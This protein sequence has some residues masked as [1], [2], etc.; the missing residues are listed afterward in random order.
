MSSKDVWIGVAAGAGAVLAAPFVLPIVGAVARPLAREV[1]KVSLI[2]AE[3]ARLRGAMALEALDD[4][5][6]EAREDA[7]LVVELREAR[8]AGRKNERDDVR[9]DGARG[10]A[11]GGEPRRGNGARPS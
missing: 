8:R 1:V 3:L 4:L 11:R 7:R 9:G 10:G 6:A 2:V 5:V